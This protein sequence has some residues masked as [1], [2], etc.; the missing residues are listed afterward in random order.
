MKNQRIPLVLAL[1]IVTVV[2]MQGIFILIGL[3]R[4]NQL[5]DSVANSNTQHISQDASSALQA[6]GLSQ[7]AVSVSNDKVYLIDS[8]LVLP[9]TKESASLLY[10]SREV[11]PQKE[12]KTTYDVTT[13]A[14][15]ALPAQ[16]FQD[17]FACTPVRFSFETSANPYNADEKPNPAIKLSDG[18]TLQVYTYTNADCDAQWQA[19]GVDPSAIAQLF[20]K[21]TSY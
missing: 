11:G 14:L 3:S 17:Q 7:P 18:R 4:I 6:V 8:R 9:L 1:L 13:R 2:V 10:S 15:A 5:E 16:G 19:A 12:L 20:A 21:A